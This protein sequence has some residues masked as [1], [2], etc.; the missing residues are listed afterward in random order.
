MRLAR[1]L[2]AYAGVLPRARRNRTDLMGWMVRRPALLG[3]I[4]AYETAVVL[5]NRI[6]PRVKTLA[7]LK[8]SMR[9]GCPF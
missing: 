1:K 4:G 5:S 8:A 3:A 6:D 7:T 2:R 9:T